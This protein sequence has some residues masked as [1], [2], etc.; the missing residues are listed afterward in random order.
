MSDFNTAIIVEFR[1][2]HGVVG[3][4]FGSAL[5]L[6]HTTGAKSGAPRINPVAHVMDGD[7]VVVIA[8]KAG[9]PDN[10]AWFH[11][12]VAH[13]QV[14]VETGSEMYDAVASVVE[15]PDRARL[16]AKMVELMPGF[17]DYETKTSRVIPVVR[18]RRARRTGS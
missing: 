1:Q 15:E 3:R 12:L 13:P 11:N 6:L 5:V 7:D 10:P 17:A 14:Q 2:N 16:F 4:G 18:L 9:A 8:S